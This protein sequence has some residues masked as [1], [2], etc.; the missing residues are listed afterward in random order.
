[1]SIDKIL[2][3][4]QQPQQAIILGAGVGAIILSIAIHSLKKKHTKK[5]LEELDVRYNEL[6][7]TPLSFK[8][9]KTMALAKANAEVATLVPKCKEQYD[10]VQDAFSNIA[11]S[12]AE[13][14]DL[15]YMHKRKKAMEKIAEVEE[16][17]ADIAPT[18]N[19]LSDFMD[20][21]LEKES[22]QRAD[23]TK[24]KELYR[25]LRSIYIEHSGELSFVSAHMDEE[26]KQIEE[27]FTRFEEYIFASEFDSSKEITAQITERLAHFKSMIENVPS[28][29]ETAQGK[30]KSMCGD[31]SSLYLQA[32]EVGVVLNHLEI[33]K[34]LDLVRD[35]MAQDLAKLKNGELEDCDHSLQECITRLN[36]LS[37]QIEREAKAYESF[38]SISD[39]LRKDIDKKLEYMVEFK[40]M[41]ERNRER[42][43]YEDWT[44]FLND[45]TAQLNA[46]KGRVEA[47]IKE[48]QMKQTPYSS[49]VLTLKE[50]EETLTII[51]KEITA[52]SDKLKNACRDEHRAIE[53][54]HKLQLIMHE[55]NVKIRKER[56]PS[57]ADSFDT[58]MKEGYH[59]LAEIERLLEQVPLNI[60]RLNAHL[61]IAI[62]HIYKLY[63]NVNNLV[64]SAAMVENALVYGNKYRSTY[65]DVDSELTRAELCF[66]NGEYTQAL[67]IAIQMIEKIHPGSY[68]R[69]IRSQG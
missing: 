48:H 62:E 21:V 57:I 4:I 53:Q 52:L 59:E 28:I 2:E 56:L 55:V 61:N 13:A 54:L 49:L 25:N 44:I 40:A 58:A 30:I 26:C 36:Q 20:Q 60:E 16:K 6:R 45:K 29:L 42:F 11:S 27:L 69:L 41:Y 3:A 24:L 37:Q 32:R 19:D 15:I 23:I 34:N 12:L 18:V 14:D 51:G 9:Q 17:L 47:L 22:M 67:T 63:N 66:R 50:Y 46:L 38:I 8:L 68:E 31:V 64:G 35:I 43:G 39:Q 7:S 65:P 33:P 1:M 10:I 5:L